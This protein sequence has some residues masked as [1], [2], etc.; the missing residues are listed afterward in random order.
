M[1]VLAG[2][3]SSDAVEWVRA[4]YRPEAVETVEQERWVDWFAQWT[5]RV[6]QL[7]TTPG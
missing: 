4:A 6:V 2:V 1:A 5:S 3:P 7:P